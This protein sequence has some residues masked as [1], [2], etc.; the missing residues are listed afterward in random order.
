[1]MAQEHKS[2][3]RLRVLR[4]GDRGSTPAPAGLIAGLF[5]APRRAAPSGQPSEAQPVERAPDAQIVAETKRLIL[6]RFAAIDYPAYFTMSAD[7]AMATF[8][9]RPPAGPDEAWMRLL[10]QTGHWSLFGYGFLAVEEKATGCLVG[11][12]GLA[13]FRRGLG[14]DFD[15]VPEAG[16]A[17]APWAQG[18][19]Y[20]TEAAAAALQWSE[21]RFGMRRT[22]C[23]IHS[24]NASSLRV[25]EKLG[26]TQMGECQYRGY[27][28]ITMER[29]AAVML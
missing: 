24:R 19:G 28:A 21:A 11:E 27:R 10:R 7:P 4:S 15:C 29:G 23:L 12:A 3:G 13:H 5:G 20:A 16:W 25:A 1:M 6:R 2:N 17:I 14:S 22:V 18:H 8:A 26:Y 9:G